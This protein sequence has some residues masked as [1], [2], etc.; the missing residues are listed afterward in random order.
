MR[1]NTKKIKKMILAIAAAATATPV[2][3]KI[4]ATIATIK[5]IK[6]HTNI[7]DFLTDF[8]KIKNIAEKSR[9]ARRK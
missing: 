3:P 9:F 5:N 2:K 8:L 1:N 4:P 6:T 7:I